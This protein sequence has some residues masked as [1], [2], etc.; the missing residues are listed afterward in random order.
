MDEF[1]LNTS[2]VRYALGSMQFGWSM[3]SRLFDTSDANGCVH[4]AVS[5]TVLL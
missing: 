5:D 1:V 2:C 4:A 3:L